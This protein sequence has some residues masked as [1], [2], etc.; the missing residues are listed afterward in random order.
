MLK[1][2]CFYNSLFHKQERLLLLLL[3]LLLL[4]LHCSSCA[5]LNAAAGA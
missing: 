2:H 4:I 1:S 3:L 5:T